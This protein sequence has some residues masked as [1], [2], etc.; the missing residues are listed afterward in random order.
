MKDS[1]KIYFVVCLAVGLWCFSI[2][3]AP[4]AA[5]TG[6][7]PVAKELYSF[8]G[9]IC[10]Q[11]DARSFHLEGNKFGVCIRCSA[12]YFGFF[13]GLLIAPLAGFF[14][15]KRTPS[16]SLFIFVTLP[17]VLDVVLNHLGVHSST[18]LTRLI[19][20]GLFG[21]AM[22]WWVIPI[23]TEAVQQ[24]LRLKK[25][26]PIDSGVYPYVRKTS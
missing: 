26:Q 13:A 3:A 11:N 23:L 19:T 7:E 10:H 1:Y 20:G 6:F 25:N 21:S 14:H 12:I 9:H 4:L 17:M 2:L 5:S 8:F 16:S 24:V 22:P 18:L 15:R